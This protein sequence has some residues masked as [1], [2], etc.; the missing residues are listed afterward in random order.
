MVNETNKYGFIVDRIIKLAFKEEK[1]VNDHIIKSNSY[2]MVLLK[3]ETDC[4]LEKVILCS[5]CSHEL[6]EKEIIK[7]KY[8]SRAI[9][10]DTCKKCDV[11]LK[12]FWCQKNH[13]SI[14]CLLSRR[15]GI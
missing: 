2:Y 15:R 14:N 1:C 13:G 6:L 9:L 10:P 7:L 4:S 12:W 3:M 5:E 11:K 8:F